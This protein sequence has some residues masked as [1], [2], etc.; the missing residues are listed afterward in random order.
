ME[1]RCL[2][3]SFT[4]FV[5]HNFQSFAREHGNKRQCYE[6][7][8]EL[9]APYKTS[10]SFSFHIFP[11][12]IWKYEYIDHTADLTICLVL[13]TVTTVINK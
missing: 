1:K 3:K 2:Q 5:W 13:K 12:T 4:I 10:F 9:G 8:G 7:A 6:G 11:S